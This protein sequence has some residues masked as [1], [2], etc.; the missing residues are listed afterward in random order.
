MLRGVPA[1]LDFPSLELQ[2][3]GAPTARLDGTP[4]PAKVLWRKHLAL[5]T[6]LALSPGRTRS[7]EHLL[8]LLWP[9]KKESYARHSLNQ[10]VAILRGLLGTARLL[11]HG[12][13][14]TLSDT[15]LDVDA[16]R[17]DA[18]VDRQPAEAAQLL[19]GEFL[20]GFAL[21]EAPGFDE[22]AGNTRARF[23]ARAAAALTAAG[24]GALGAFRYAEA[25]DLARRALAYEPY[26]E[27][28]ARLLMRAAALSGDIAGALAAFQDFSARMASQLGERPGRAL[29]DLAERVRSMR[30]RRSTALRAAEEPALVGREALYREAFAVVEAGLRGGPRTL[31]VTGDPGAGRTRLLVECGERLALGGAVLASARP[32]ES[33]RESP[34]STLRALL[35]GGLLRAPGSTAVDPGVLAALGDAATPR[36]AAEMA[37]A[38]AALLRAIADEQPV[39]IS[40]D[41]A[42]FADGPSLGALEVALGELRRSP[43]PVVLVVTALHG[44]DGMPRELVRL[45]AAVGRSLPGSALRLEPFTEEEARLLVL[46]SSPW[47]QAEADRDRLARRVFFETAGNPF[48]IVTLLRGLEQASALRDEVL[49][50]PPPRGTIEAPLPIAVPSLARRAIMGRVAELDRDTIRVLQGVSIGVSRID[51]ELVAALTGASRDAVLERLALLE[52]RHFVTFD[53]E[54]Y[55][56]AA[57]LVAEVVSTEGLPPGECRSLRIR[58]L[59]LLA[60]RQDAESRLFRAQLLA[61]TGSHRAP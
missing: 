53:G 28:A 48:L 26:A 40:V 58:A 37:T 59:D 32:L 15:A 11:T 7:R 43:S 2:C 61:L 4:A 33:D 6:Y 60:T 41:D 20:E 25:I 27:P 51:V 1:P 46:G 30:W 49:T 13:S 24:E 21:D 42:H 10:A 3:F 56:I 31:L 29:S 34:W 5:L 14:L 57:P 54:R 45:S 50:W 18:L 35:R 39:G 16:E 12:D 38:L 9:E 44:W 52:R 22:W 17:F 23:H 19:R 55:T 8:G 47:C 36:D